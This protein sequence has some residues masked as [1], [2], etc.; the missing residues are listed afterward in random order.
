MDWDYSELANSYHA[1]PAY[2]DD[3]IEAIVSRAAAGKVCDI[4]AGTGHLTVALLDRGLTVDA[5][6]PNPQMRQIGIERTEDRGVTW[7][8]ATAESTGLAGGAYSLVT[9]GSSFNVVDRQ[10][11]LAEAARLLNPDG[12]FA[13]L[14]NCLLYTSPS[15]RDRTRSRMPSSA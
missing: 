4:G 14:W 10:A 7:R 1:R 9:F 3:A 2:A 5:V 13:C 12:V 6:E 8:A 11:A 15:P